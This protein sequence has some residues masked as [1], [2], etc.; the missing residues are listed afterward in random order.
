[1]KSAFKK[2]P[3]GKHSIDGGLLFAVT[4]CAAIST[5]LIYSITHNKVLE[6]VGSSYWKTQAFSM[7]A[8][9]VAA[10]VISFIDY[11]KLVKLWVVFVPVALALTA[12]ELCR[13]PELL[14]AVRAEH[15][16]ALDIQAGSV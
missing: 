5:L 12:L 11:R 16:K 2:L 6:T 4:L 15:K 7:A 14:S 13:D 10:V 9:I 1:M 8:G 3:S